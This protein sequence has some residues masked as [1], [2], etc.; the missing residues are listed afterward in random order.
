[1]IPNKYNCVKCNKELKTVFEGE[2]QPSKG[3]VFT[4]Y[5]HYGSTYFDPLDGVS[6]IQIIVCDVCLNKLDDEKKILKGKSYKKSN[7]ILEYE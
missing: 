5:G 4:T 6:F 3:L 2:V 7:N 1:M